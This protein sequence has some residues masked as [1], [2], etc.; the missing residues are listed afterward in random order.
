[1]LS[2][3]HSRLS[4]I[5]EEVLLIER[6]PHQSKCQSQQRH[7][8]HDAANDPIEYPDAAQIELAA[9]FVHKISDT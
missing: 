7:Q 9:H 3:A 8:H 4:P 6:L 1:M 5:R 2:H